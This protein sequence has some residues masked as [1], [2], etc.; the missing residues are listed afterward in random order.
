M[1]VPAKYFIILLMIWFGVMSHCSVNAARILE[2][3]L[4]VKSEPQSAALSDVGET[5]KNAWVIEE[6]ASR[7]SS[8][9]DIGDITIRSYT[10][11]VSAIGKGKNVHTESNVGGIKVNND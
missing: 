6:S 8:N 10:G 5:E 4:V 9:V 11:S 3:D 7:K 1:T 2:S